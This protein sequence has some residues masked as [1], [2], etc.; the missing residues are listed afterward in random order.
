MSGIRSLVPPSPGGLL[1]LLALAMSLSMNVYAHAQ[2]ITLKRESISVKSLFLEIRKQTGYDV[3][4]ESAMV[5]ALPAVSVNASRSS[6]EQVLRN[7]L[8]GVGLDFVVE[9]RT[10]SVYRRQA[11]AREAAVQQPGIIK[12]KVVDETGGPLPDVIIKV[13]GNEKKFKTNV[14]GEFSIPAD[15]GEE[16]I[17]SFIGYTP[18]TVKVKDSKPLLVKMTG[19]SVSL[20]NVVVNGIFERKTSSYT[21]AAHTLQTKDLQKVSNMNLLQ[22]LTALDPAVQLP[23]DNLNGSDPNKAANIRLRGASSIPTADQLSSSA[24]STNLTQQDNYAAY[25]KRVDQIKNTYN[26]NANLP[27]F[28]L[29]GFEVSISQITDMDMTTIKSV[30][31]LKDA[32]STAIYGSRGANGVIVIERIK[33]ESSQ[34]LFNYKA[35]LTFNLP[36]LSDYELLNAREKLYAENLAGVY[37][38][39]NTAISEGLKILY[40]DRLKEVERG[41][42]FDWLSVPLRNSLTQRHGLNMSGNAANVGYGIDFTYNNNAGV[43]KGSGRESFNGDIYLNYRGK[44]FSINNRTSLQFVNADNSPWGTFSQYVRMN[45]YFSPY[46]ESGNIKL[47]LQRKTGFGQQ[48]AYGDILNPVYNTTLNGRD[49]SKT[50]TLIN[51]TALTYNLN[52][53]LSVRGRLSLT[54]GQNDQGIFRPAGHTSYLQNNTALLSRGEMTMGYGKSFS[55]DANID[56]NYNKQFG[57]HLISS[58]VNARAYENTFE[59]II[60]QVEGMPSS[61]TDYLFYARGY[62]GSRPGGSEG[63]TRTL[64]FL[65]NINYT[66]DNRYFADFSYRL[67]GASSL[68]SDQP[69]APFWSAG[70]GWN[71]HNEKFL[72]NLLIKGVINQIRLRGSVGMTGSQQ[73][74]PYMAYRTYNYSLN[75]AYGVSVGAS[76][77]AIGNENLKWQATIKHNVGLDLTLFNS[78]LSFTGDIYYDKTDKFIAD[79]SLPPS[80]GFST[81][82][83]NLGSISSKGWEFRASVQA[84]QSSKPKG[85]LLSLFGN[86][87]HNTSIIKEISDDLKAQNEKLASTTS[88]WTPFTRYAAGAPIN[89]LWV[90]P[91]L[92]IDPTTGRELFLNQDGTTTFVWD[93]KNMRNFGVTDPKYQGTLGL[94]VSYLGFQLNTFMSYQF[95]G[96]TYNQTLID[97][98]ENVN[99]VYNA[100]RRVL[101]ERWTKPGDVAAFKAIQINGANTNASSRFVQDDNTLT[102]TSAS[103]LYRINPELVKFMKL[104]QLNI[105]LYT[106]NLFRISTVKMERGLD[107]PFAQNFSLSLQASF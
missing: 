1:Y 51:N 67:D 81:Y 107:Y 27:L 53:D 9:G 63:T 72:H 15:T 22:A 82:K 62:A 105:G 56:L 11:E 60:V 46:D 42:D 91:S 5:N 100:D 83:G 97:R 48:A 69:F 13:K 70:A 59:N 3:V 76:L 79:F 52:K 89:S 74:D 23:I 44:Q 73:F 71:V 49:F 26:T 75:E 54:S 31:I 17:F 88:K 39:G 29:D 58:T 87:S 21:G 38:N 92:G 47:Y 80:T 98:V 6:L 8:H 85:F 104:R 28:I 41:R 78:R 64:G 36:D 37:T 68:G 2:T 7:S 14:D 12:G 19:S 66:Y 25:G 86:M 10:I 93:S 94:S 4:F 61:L 35:D 50:K 84:V 24:A 96:Q 102:M 95:G 106:S 103:L 55:Y 18:V 77:L 33:P 101:T 40:N 34:I 16:L 90:V 30:T 43:L 45:P 65:G 57:P 20:G 32:S 99:L